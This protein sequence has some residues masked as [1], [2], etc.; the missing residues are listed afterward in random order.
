M[1]EKD[2]ISL[3]KKPIAAT[4]KA[5]FIAGFS[6][7][8]WAPLIPLTKERLQVDNGIMGAILLAFGLGSLLMMPLSGMLA[9]RFGCRRVF[10]LALLLVLATLPALVK[11]EDIIPLALALFLFG[12][13]IGAMDVVVNIHAVITE[14]YA[15]RPIMSGFHALFSLG[16]IAGAAA[17]SALLAGGI[18]PLHV[19]MIVIVLLG[20][21]MLF[22]WSGLMDKAERRET[23][24]FVLPK[25]VV[26]VL[27]LL[28][29]I[30]YVME[31]SMLDWSGILLISQHNIDIHQAGLGYTLFAITM[32]LGRFLGDKAIAMLG[33]KRIFIG[34]AILATSGF[35]VLIAS[36]A[37]LLT[38]L[39]FLLIGMGVANIAPMLFTAS[40]QQKDMPD[41]LAVAAVSTLGYSG[42]LMGP[43][44]IGFV[45]H[46]FSLI[47]A[48]IFVTLLSI[49]LLVVSCR[50]K[51]TT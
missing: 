12:A 29:C 39:A 8:S 3:T 4:R 32:T 28:C 48:F 21:I 5:F 16:G 40:G 51:L 34:S 11:L 18:S 9:V 46:L 24:F 43:A 19:V 33:A 37:L 20:L 15:Q 6:L 17:V 10:T 41:A 45:A 30:A 38:A 13:G 42:I 1:T 27:G 50:V 36:N 2:A 25:G 49:I 47:G 31:G 23:P 7:A 14:K 22:A 44:I 35:I 26:V